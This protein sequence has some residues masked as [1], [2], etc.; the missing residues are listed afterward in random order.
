MA[1]FEQ[2][3]DGL[4]VLYYD[5]QGYTDSDCPSADDPSSSSDVPAMEPSDP[6]GDG[7]SLVVCH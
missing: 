1:V 2:T 5:D 6:A 4:G 7:D 3:P